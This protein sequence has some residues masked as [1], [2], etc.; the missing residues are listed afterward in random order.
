MDACEFNAML[1]ELINRVRILRGI[2]EIQLVVGKT[3]AKLPFLIF[4]ILEEI[5][6]IQ[7]L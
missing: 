1:R 7:Y 3:S 6:Q 2:C 5:T 4:S